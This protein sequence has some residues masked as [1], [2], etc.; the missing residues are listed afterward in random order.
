VFHFDT[1]AAPGL[2]VGELSRRAG[3]T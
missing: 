3:T 2:T 1:E